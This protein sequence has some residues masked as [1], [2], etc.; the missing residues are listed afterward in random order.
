MAQTPPD[1]LKF[2][3]ALAELE[4][5]V[6]NMEG[7]ELELENSI[8]AYRRGVAL[9]KHCQKQLAEAEQQIRILEDGTLE[10]LD[11]ANREQE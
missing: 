2:E 6:R 8:N 1:D 9:L 4:G 3:A 10:T 5:I 11:A 7:G